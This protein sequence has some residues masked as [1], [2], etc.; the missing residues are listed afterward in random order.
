[1]IHAGSGLGMVQVNSAA[2]QPQTLLTLRQ[3]CEYQGG[4]LTVLQA[5]THLKQQ[6]EVWGYTGNALTLMKG[7]KT[8]FDSQNILSPGR[9]VGGI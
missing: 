5:P 3:L 7:I 6:I 4:F 8:Q 9:F 1:L 2:I